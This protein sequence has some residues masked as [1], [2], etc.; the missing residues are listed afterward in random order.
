VRQVESEVV[1]LAAALA[2]VQA[3]AAQATGAAVVR[4]SPAAASFAGQ[5]PAIEERVACS[6]ER[7]A[8]PEITVL[9]SEILAASE[10]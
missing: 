4:V 6:P 9:T 7:C 8:R 5:A 1:L 10:P 3:A 2:L